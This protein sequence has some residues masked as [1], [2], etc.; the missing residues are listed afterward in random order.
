MEY[1]IV[2]AALSKTVNAH[3][4][5]KFQ[6]CADSHVN[7]NNFP[8]PETGPLGTYSL[9]LIWV[10]FQV[11]GFILLIIGMMLYNDIII[12]PQV[13]RYLERRQ[14][15]KNINATGGIEDDQRDADERTRLIR[16]RGKM[17]RV[18]RKPDFCLCENKEADQLCSN[19]TA[20]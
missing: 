12:M 9:H 3:N 2:V 11:F 19:C 20:D 10:H 16:D 8:H 15:M 17:S 7:L 14:Q 18:I 5:L 1:T 4:F 6:A 13:R